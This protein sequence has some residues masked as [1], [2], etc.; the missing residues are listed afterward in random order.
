MPSWEVLARK[1]DRLLSLRYDGSL[2]LTEWYG[3]IA[4]MLTPET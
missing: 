3:E 4:A 1:G 2:D